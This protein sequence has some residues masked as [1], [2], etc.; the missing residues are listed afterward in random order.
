MSFASKIFA[1]KLTFQYIRSHI[2]TLD[3]TPDEDT[4]LECRNA[5]S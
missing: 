4:R 3:I 2:A 1:T 5:G